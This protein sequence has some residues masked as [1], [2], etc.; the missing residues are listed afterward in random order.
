MT[1]TTTDRPVA[2]NEREPVHPPGESGGALGLLGLAAIAA[3]L[4]GCGGGGVGE[5]GTTALA[6]ANGADTTMVPGKEAKAQAQARSA[7]LL[8]PLTREEASRFLSQAGMGG[9]ADEI[10]QVQAIGFEAWLTAQFNEPRS[11]SYVKLISSGGEDRDRNGE[12]PNAGGKYAAQ[13]ALWRKFITGKDVLRQRVTLALSEIFVISIDGVT[14]NNRGF[15]IA[16]YMDILE[17]NAFGNVR[18]LLL[19]VSTSSAMG[20]YLTF[21]NSKK[22]NTVTGS[23]PDENYARELMQL[24]SIGLVK[25]NQDGTTVLENG[26]PVETYTQTDVAGLARVFTGWELN[27]DTRPET[28][29]VTKP[30]QQDAKW[31]E[32]GE[33]KFLGATIPANTN[34]EESL[35]LAIDVLM[36]H[37]NIGPFIGRQLIQR[38]VKSNPSPAYVARVAAAFN[39]T[40][41]SNKGDLKATLLAVL[42]DTEARS[43][44]GLSDPTHGKLRE[45]MLRFLHWARIVKLSDSKKDRYDIGELSSPATQLGQSPLRSPSVFNFFRPGYVPPNGGLGELGVTAPEFQITNESSV[46]GYLNFM[47][48]T[49][50]NGLADSEPDYSVLKQLAANSAGLLGELNVLLAAGQVSTATLAALA[51]ALDDINVQTDSGKLRRVQAAM[52]LLMAAPEYLVQK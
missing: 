42:L 20:T 36:A 4:P 30:M 9:T 34:G 11:K 41:P 18:D 35:R 3:A 6:G 24:F 23:Q 25:L 16:A 48:K 29:K 47:Q 44:A 17:S 21:L 14:G 7:S 19:Q 52:L 49:V 15:A 37:P 2:A 1:V 46:A 33:K 28:D 50:V 51:K 8:A 5:A 22:A 31:H 13:R 26:K 32:S 27:S 12:S 10:V 40:S 39:G 43:S 38:L 45:P